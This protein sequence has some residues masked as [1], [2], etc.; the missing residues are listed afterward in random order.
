MVFY[1]HSNSGGLQGRGNHS[2]AWADY[3]VCPQLAAETGECRAISE[4]WGGRATIC[5]EVLARRNTWSRSQA[6]YLYIYNYILY[7]CLCV[8]HQYLETLSTWEHSGHIW[9][10]LG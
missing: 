5:G 8:S 10:G 4:L 1:I 2:R 3:R 9:Q 6:M 7:T